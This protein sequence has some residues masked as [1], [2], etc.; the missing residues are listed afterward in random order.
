MKASGING[1][2]FIKFPI[3]L[4]YFWGG[5]AYH[6]V[7]HMNSKIPFYNL[8]AYH[9]EVVSKSNLF[10]DVVTLSMSDCYNNLWLVLYDEEK[11]KYIT[12]AE[13]D[14]EIRKYKNV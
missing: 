3:Y 5:E 6:H 12:F 9:E 2:S 8:K 11:K 14:E 13:A 1:S 7:H 10:D 4:E